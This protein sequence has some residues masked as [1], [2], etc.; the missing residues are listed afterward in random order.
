MKSFS[1]LINKAR[2][3]RARIKYRMKTPVLQNPGYCPTCARRVTFVARDGWL[4]DHYK[5]ARCGSI[6]RERA[7]M[8]VIETYFP[9]WRELVVHESSPGKRGTSK[10]L[11][12]ECANYV[13]SQ[14]FPDRQGGSRVGQYRCENLEQLSFEDESI[15]L[16]VSQDVMEHVFHPDKAFQEIAR[17]LKPGG[18][19]LFTVPTVNKLSA[20]RLRARLGDDGRA[21][22]LQPPE[23]HG[24]PVSDGGALVTVDWGFDICRYIFDA[25]GLFTHVM[26]ID[27]PAQGIR[28]EYLQVYATIKPAR[29]DPGQGGIG[30]S[31]GSR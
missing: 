8:R 28:A 7:L 25:C 13:P 24:N 3:L 15:D 16:H 9:H 22:H 1:P 30:V 12:D 26:Y 21:E 4:R 29:P 27:D 17:T 2:R 10:R 23:Y 20:S 18:A 31:G 6:P 11:A 14:Y 5:C 19:H